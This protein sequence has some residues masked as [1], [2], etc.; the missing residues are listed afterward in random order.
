MSKKGKGKGKPLSE[1]ADRTEEALNMLKDMSP[2]IREEVL[3]HCLINQLFSVVSGTTDVG[4]STKVL[5]ECK[6][7]LLMKRAQEE[8]KKLKPFLGLHLG[9]RQRPFPS[10]P[11]SPSATAASEIVIVKALWNGEGRSAGLEDGDVLQTVSS[12]FYFCRL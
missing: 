3:S 5:H 9:L 6:R 8:Y 1:D 10:S 7:A 12:L 11:S 2:E 4:L